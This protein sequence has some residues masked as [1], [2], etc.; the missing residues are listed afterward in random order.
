MQRFWVILRSLGSSGVLLSLLALG[1]VL[2]VLFAD[3]FFAWY[4]VPGKVPG[5]L[6][7]GFLLFLL[8]LAVLSYG[9]VRAWIRYRRGELGF[10]LQARMV[11]VFV[12]V[13]VVPAALVSG[14]SSL[15]FDYGARAW[16]HGIVEP[17]V[18][19][20]CAAALGREREYLAAMLAADASRFV[21][22]LG[23][24]PY[25][26]DSKVR[27]GAALFGFAEV[28]VIGREGVLASSMSSLLPDITSPVGRSYGGKA[29]EAPVENALVYAV[30]PVHAPSITH[31]VMAR[32]LPGGSGCAYDT[33]SYRKNARL[34]LSVLQVQFS[35]AFLFIFLMLL[36]VS[37]WLGVGLSKSVVGPLSHLLSA[38]KRVQD[39]NF[40]CKIHGKAGVVDEEMS[41]VIEAF[42]G[43]V[44]QLGAQRLQLEKAYK[45]ISSRKE[46]IETVL[47][48]VSSGIMA[49]SPS[50]EYVTLMNNRARELLSFDGA[51]GKMC[52]I[53]PEACDL[54][55]KVA[56]KA[57]VTIVRE[58]KALTLSVHMRRLGIQGLI[59][60]FDDI[61]GLVEA[62]RQ[63]AWSDVARRIAH[64]I[65]NPVT[66]IYLAAERLRSKYAEQIVS[67]R[68]TF[69]KYTDTITKHVSSIS[70]IVDEFAKFARMPSAVF[71]MCDIC[72]LLREASFAGQ[73]GQK[74]V[75]FDLRFPDEAVP[76]LL[77]R[78]QISQVF[79][80][81]FKNA[82]ESIDARENIDG[83][84][85]TVAVT[86]N[87]DSVAVEVK[88]N[89]VGFPPDLIGRLTEPYVTTRDQGTG[90]GL[91]IVKK[92]LDE[93][94]ASIGFRNLEEGGAV[95]ITFVL[96]E[97]GGVGLLD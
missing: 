4:V 80:N 3:P 22:Y 17:A 72:S 76:V 97:R 6:L 57:N 75:D 67:G 25:G 51:H 47:S 79:I 53:F 11:L 40:D 96:N 81:V 43:M 28:L 31:V 23:D 39:G 13:G 88:D 68:E 34:Q 37:V 7:A 94:G 83:G 32:A 15:F 21:E 49:L 26:S 87:I 91:A 44:E 95:L 85:I 35:L 70:E 10:R 41:T 24:L 69:L 18:S 20:C 50:G 19:S 8:L 92:I 78:E 5:S 2:L 65:K 74:V 77:D 58:N 56:D 45:E 66:P 84:H 9:M 54:L 16:F 12:V 14:F 86:K 48:G 64:E 90:L 60:T 36:F 42:N 82:C 29:Q 33:S 89:G 55:N 30:V 27:E 59:M 62:Q 46:F 93:H 38:T 73:F 71:E 1:A 63:A 52:H 61:S